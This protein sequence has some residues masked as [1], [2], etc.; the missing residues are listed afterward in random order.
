MN[1]KSLELYLIKFNF[2]LLKNLND[3]YIDDTI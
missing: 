2:K 3:E 1:I